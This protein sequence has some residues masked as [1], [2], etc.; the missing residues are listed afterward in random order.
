MTV[1]E[2]E[3]FGK[4]VVQH[5]ETI[6]RKYK[7]T[8]VKQFLNEGKRKISIYRIIKQHT[9]IKIKQQNKKYLEGIY[10]LNLHKN[11]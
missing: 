4:P 7:R 10:H 8:T 1:K 6:T 9:K 3:V 2:N 5:W 11:R